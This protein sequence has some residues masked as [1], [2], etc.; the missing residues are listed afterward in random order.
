[1]GSDARSQIFEIQAASTSLQSQMLALV[2]SAAGQLMGFG[3][4]PNV[5]VS[6]IG[7][8]EA[9]SLT[10]FPTAPGV[11]PF[12]D[13]TTP[14]A[15]TAPPVET[16]EVADVVIPTLT[17]T[18]PSIVFPTFD[19]IPFPTA[20]GDAP[21]L[22]DITVPADPSIILPSPPVWEDFDIPTMP[23]YVA[24]KFEGTRPTL[25]AMDTPGQ[26]FFWE[27]SSFSPA[28]W[29]ALQSQLLADIQG[30]GD[31][32]SILALAGMFAEQERWVAEQGV[33]RKE[34]IEAR[35]RARGFARLTGAARAEMRL[36]DLDIEKSLAA[37]KA[38]AVAKQAELSIQY[39]QFL[40]EQATGLVVNVEL[41][42][43]NASNNRAIEAG[44][45]AGEFAYQDLDARVKWF[46]ASLALFQADAAVLEAKIKAALGE[47][48]AYKTAMEG[49][50]IRG[51]LRD[52][53]VKA[54]L[55]QLQGVSQIVE[56]FKGRLQG[57]QVAADI[58]KTRLQAHEIQVQS[59]VASVNAVRAQYDAKV[60]Q[61]TG[62]KVKSD[63]YDSQ[64]RAF[65]AQLGGAKTV[66]EIGAIKA[67]IVSD[68]NKTATAI[69]QGAVEAYRAEWS[70]V[71]AQVEK[72]SKQADAI[73]RIYTAEV[74]GASSD[75]DSRVRKFVADVQAFVAEMDASVKEAGL[76][77]DHG[78]A[79]A[80]LQQRAL[81]T[82]AQVS[83]QGLSAALQQIHGSA[84][85]GASDSVSESTSKSESVSESTVTSTSQSNSSSFSE[86]Y[87]YNQSISA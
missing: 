71:S 44:K 53:D 38:Q 29:E 79:N 73:A 67:G 62:E 32:T 30:G 19:D 1:M 47:L 41:A 85:L 66:A 26:V 10:S 7:S 68:R 81:S 76:I 78:K 15:P 37:T 80:E 40:L 72:M 86:N 58:Q 65:V 48:D 70:G 39:R 17:A 69:Y 6:H 74:Q 2:N 57:A 9:P 46:N 43:W 59:F 14:T 55:G 3:G 61:I 87:N 22:T 11:P 75:N 18:P 16:A 51:E 27:E 35:C 28:L 77:L 5:S 56:I 21:A 82:I 50:R 25:P 34:V 84:S 8:P 63:V 60:A 24:A 52:S 49:A 64:V 42:K 4:I 33:Q 31:V 45:I 83:G 54:Y 13:I 23:D 20:P 12:G 36:I